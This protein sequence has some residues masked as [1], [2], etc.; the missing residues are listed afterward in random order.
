MKRKNSD[1]KKVPKEVNYIF[2]YSATTVTSSSSSS[3][4]G[5][6]SVTMIQPY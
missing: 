4:Y 2:G 6:F 3:S 5:L 1:K